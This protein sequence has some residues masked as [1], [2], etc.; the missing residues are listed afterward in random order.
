MKWYA[1]RND[2]NLNAYGKIM[3]TIPIIHKNVLISSQNINNISTLHLM[4]LQLYF[5]AIFRNFIPNESIS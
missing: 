1:N 5:Q 4:L 2:R 3:K